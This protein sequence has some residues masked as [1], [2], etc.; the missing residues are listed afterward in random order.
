MSKLAVLR[1]AIRSY[2]FHLTLLVILRSTRERDLVHG[3]ERYRVGVVSAKNEC[4][5]I[6]ARLMKMS[7]QPSETKL[8][9]P[10][11]P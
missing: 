8:Y 5:R 6:G 9:S 11:A 1:E 2:P 4:V 3:G 10:S 7:V